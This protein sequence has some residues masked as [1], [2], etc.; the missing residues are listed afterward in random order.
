[1]IVG[2][3]AICH[4]P[5]ALLSTKYAPNSP[6]FA[7]QGYQLTSWSDAEERLVERT[8]GGEIP[9]VESTLAFEGARMVSAMGK[10][11]GGITVDREVVGGRAWH[12]VRRHAGCVGMGNQI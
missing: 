11:L 8:Q 10:K 5:L 12:E 4:G 2:T 7:Y 9:K 1:M 3:A 6:S